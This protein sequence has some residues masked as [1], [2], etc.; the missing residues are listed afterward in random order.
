MRTPSEEVAEVV[1]QV[2]KRKKLLLPDDSDKIKAKIA[3]GTMKSE[4]WLLVAEKAVEKGE[5]L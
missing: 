2:I 4:D 5:N 3:A 1:I